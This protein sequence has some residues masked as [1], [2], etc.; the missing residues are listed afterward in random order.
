MKTRNL[1]ALLMTILG[2]TL[3]SCD[4][5]PFGE[6]LQCN[7]AQID[8]SFTAGTGE[9]WCLS[10]SDL[11]IQFTDVVEDSRCNVSDITCVW[12]GRYVMAATLLYGGE[13]IQDTFYAQHGW[14]DTL[15]TGPYKIILEKVKP[16]TRES[17]EPLE[18][19]AYNF[20]V[21]IRQ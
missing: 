21:V 9:L 5:A 8:K 14:R 13:S 10:G 2:W 15:Y 17:M 1:I 16:E 20:D 6:N 19:E 12:A 7:Q 3:M 18:D 11:K 4:K